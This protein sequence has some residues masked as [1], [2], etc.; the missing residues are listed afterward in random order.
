MK[1]NITIRTVDEH[2]EYMIVLFDSV[3]YTEYLYTHV[4]NPP[5]INILIKQPIIPIDML[6]WKCIKT[7]IYYAN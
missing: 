1:L 5:P 6:H 3:E 4:I 7:G 2:G